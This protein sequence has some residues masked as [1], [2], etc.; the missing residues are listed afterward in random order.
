MGYPLVGTKTHTKR[1]NGVVLLL[2]AAAMIAAS[3]AELIPSALA[4]DSGWADSIF[5][6]LM[7]FAVFALIKLISSQLQKR[8]TR[9]I[10]SATVVTIA[11]TLHNIP[12]GTAAVAAAS[13]DLG[14]GLGTGLAIGLQN[15]PE[16]LSIAA[17][18][19]AAGASRKWAFGMVAISAIAEVMG[20]A[21]VWLS[22]D[23]LNSEINSH[24]LL[25]VAAIMLAISFVEL[26]PDGIRLVQSRG[27]TQSD[28]N[29]LKAPPKR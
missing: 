20:A 9:L 19:L 10:G 18:A 26:I 12:E 2:A 24:L 21:G 7:G 4:I 3:V 17:L 23:L 8:A 29:E 15:V 22:G 13:A 25:M 14:A 6:L 5:W 11:L 1:F 16:G 28:A 27:T